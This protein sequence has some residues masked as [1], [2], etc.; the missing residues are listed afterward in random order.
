VISENNKF[1]MI[2]IFIVLHGYEHYF[3]SQIIFKNHDSTT[4]TTYYMIKCA[5]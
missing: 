2:F 5:I 1:E 3:T 4:G